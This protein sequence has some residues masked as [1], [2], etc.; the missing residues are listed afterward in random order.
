MFNKIFNCKR[1]VSIVLSLVLL[2]SLLT[3]CYGNGSYSFPKLTGSKD[4]SSSS[5]ESKS[6][7]IVCTI[8]PIADW[9]RE[10]TQDSGVD[11]QITALENSSVD[12]HSFQPSA[13]DII[14]IK[15]SDL[16]IYI[17]GESDE[18]AEKIV[19]ENPNLNYIKLLD[20]IKD[21]ALEEEDIGIADKEYIG[22]EADNEADNKEELEYDEHIW[23]SLHNA[24]TCC[25]ALNEEL[26]TILPDEK[27]IFNIAT[28]SYVSYLNTLD[29]KYADMVS[30]ADTKTLLFCDRFPFRY[31][32]EDYNLKCYAAFQGCSAETEASFD[33]I[34][35][36]A[37]K[38]QT[39]KIFA[40][41]VLDGSSIDITG[42]V[43]DT[44]GKKLPILTINAMQ[45]A[46]EAGDTYISI[47]EYNLEVL[48]QALYD[49][50]EDT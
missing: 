24:V 23:L 27:E 31:L 41:L 19:E 9:T 47:M 38:L 8:F 49:V 14:K 40:V 5:A 3:S 4:S 36:L 34:K 46:I 32:A 13:E 39:E 43:F 29:Q 16:F 10:I 44:A 25:N 15:E 21:A 22:D 12:M 35:F 45:S 6:T 2:L 7:S 11:I 48:R 26:S 37:D 17:G 50:A 42:T 28:V 18:W 20:V 33:V 1:I 30:K